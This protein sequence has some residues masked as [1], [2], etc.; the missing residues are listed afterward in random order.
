MCTESLGQEFSQSVAGTLCF[1]FMR[2]E[3]SARK[4]HAWGWLHGWG[5][6]MSEVTLSVCLVVDAGYCLGP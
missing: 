1:F 5:L 6:E 2:S 4:I 3:A